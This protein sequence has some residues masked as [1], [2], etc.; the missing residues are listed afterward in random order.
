MN[1]FDGQR[2][3]RPRSSKNSSAASA[4]PVQLEVAT[5]GRPF[6]AAQAASNAARQRA[7]R[8]L[9]AVEDLVPERVQARAVA[10]VEPDGEGV[11][12][13]SGGFPPG[14]AP[15]APANR[16]NRRQI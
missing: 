10:L 6:Q 12:V 9:L 3:V 1:V 11:D 8:P 16:N 15:W 13:Q 14:P 7:A 4:A 2:T 5:A